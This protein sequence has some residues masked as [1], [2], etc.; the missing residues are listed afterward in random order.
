MKQKLMRLAVI[1]GV[2]ALLIGVGLI[3]CMATATDECDSELVLDN[4]DPGTWQRIDDDREGILE[5]CPS[6]PTF[7]FGFAASGLEPNVDYS[8]IYYADK[9]D[10]FDAEQWGGNNPGAILGTG[11]AMRTSR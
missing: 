4:K 8:L 6:G 5:F 10:R 3:P 9:P 7:V 11:S 2:V 1:L